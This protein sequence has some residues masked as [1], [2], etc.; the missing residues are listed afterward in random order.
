VRTTKLHKMQ[1][2]AIQGLCIATSVGGGGES[3]VLRNALKSLRNTLDEAVAR[4]L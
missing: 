1:A 2:S 3:V 4:D